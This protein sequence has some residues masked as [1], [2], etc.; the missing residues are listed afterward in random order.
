MSDGPRTFP[1]AASPSR[2]SLTLL[3]GFGAEGCEESA[4]DPLVVVSTDGE[5]G[6]LA[7][8]LRP[9][10]D[11]DTL[12]RGALAVSGMCRFVLATSEPG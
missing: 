3:L 6:R 5:V 10:L 11:A 4:M 1:T 9:T 8:R 12:P 2:T 7:L